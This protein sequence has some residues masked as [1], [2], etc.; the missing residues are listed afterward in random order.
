LPAQTPLGDRA[1]AQERRTGRLGPAAVR[2]LRIAAACGLV[3]AVIVGG[4]GALW[5]SRPA[6]D[7]RNAASHGDRASAPGPVRLDRLPSPS[8]SARAR[9]PGGAATAGPI[10]PR[11][12]PRGDAGGRGPARRGHRGP[13]APSR[14]DIEGELAALAGESAWLQS[15]LEGYDGHDPGTGEIVWP[16]DGRVILGFGRVFGYRHTGID[17]RVPTGTAVHAADW[18]RVVQSGFM[19]GYGKYACIQHTQFLSTCYGHLSQ[20]RVR[21]GRKVDSGEVIG[22]SGCSGRCYAAHLHFEV[23]DDGRP[24]NPREYLGAPLSDIQ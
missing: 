6:E 23:R 14:A 18:G 7:S 22:R 15:A 9:G 21:E 13:S 4:A 11:P 16:V 1:G 24:V 19:K 8:A 12:R 17:I 5:L 10:E 3:A 20:V 2:R